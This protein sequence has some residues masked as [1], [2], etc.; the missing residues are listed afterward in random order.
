MAEEQEKAQ[1]PTQEQAQQAPTEA[2]TAPPAAAPE[3]APVV[4]QPAPAERPVKPLPE[5]V[6]YI[7]GLGRRKKA[8][9]RIRI[10]PGTG[11]F[12]VNLREMDKY[13]VEERDRHA[14]VSPLRVAN[15][16]KSWDIWARVNGGGF[17]G[18]AGAVTLGVARAIAKAMPEVEADLRDHGLLT[19]DSRMKERKKYGQKGARK[20]FQYSKR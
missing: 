7:W 1:S 19:R 2:P 13:F 4:E 17:A 14:V 6:R 15:V 12:V 3:P 9:A 18:Q 8:T 5:G 16:V 10:R 11:K 20:R